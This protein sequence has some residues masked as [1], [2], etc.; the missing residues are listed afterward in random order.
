MGGHGQPDLKNLDEDR[1]TLKKSILE[2]W[3][4]YVA[5]LAAH[6]GATGGVHFLHN[7]EDS[8]CPWLHATTIFNIINRRQTQLHLPPAILEE[9]SIPWWPNTR[10]SKNSLH[11]YIDQTFMRE[12]LWAQL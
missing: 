3:K 6:A 7:R 10:K 2:K 12:E 9:I 5:R 1:I 8:V 4:A 11:N